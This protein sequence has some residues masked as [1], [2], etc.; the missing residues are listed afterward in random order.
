[1]RNLRALAWRTFGW[2]HK[3]D[4]D[5]SEEIESNVQLHIDDNLKQGMTPEQARRAA[6][7]KLGGVE[8]AKE[9]YRDRATL[10]LL[11]N[12]TGDIRFALRQLRTNPGFTATAILMLSLG[13]CASVAIFA[14]VDAALLK[15]LPYKD[16]NR[17]VGVYE[18][19]EPTCPLCNLSY[20]DYLDWKQSNTVFSSFAAYN[21]QSVIMTTPSGAQLALTTRVT[22]GFFRTLGVTPLLGRDFRSGEDLLSAPRTVMLS[23]STWQQRYAGSKDVLGK[24]I[25]LNGDANVVIGVLPRAFHFAPSEPTE[26][27]TTMHAASEC[28]LRR[29]CHNLYGIARLKDG[30]TFQTALADVTG[31]AKRLEKQ[32]PGSNRDQGAALAMISDVIVGNIRPILLVLLSGACLLL[33][34]AGVNVASLLLVRTESRKRE[35]AVRASVGASRGRIVAQ[36]MAEA[37]VLVA[38]GTT[39]GLLSAYA[40]M[41]LL[42]RLL[43][44]DMLLRMPYLKELVL[45]PRVLAFA[46]LVALLALLLFASIPALRV[47]LS[48]LREGL[49]EGSRGAG[50]TWRRLGSRL[51]VVEL[52]TAVVL[53]AG[54]GLLGQSLYRL[55]SVKIGLRPDHL[56]LMRVGVSPSSYPKD[57]QVMAVARRITT[58]I[59]AIPGVLSAGIVSNVP[60]GFSGNTTWFR[61]LGRPWQGEHNDTPFRTVSPDYFKTIGATLLRGRDFNQSEDKSKPRVVIIN[62]T[63]ARHFF[64]HEDPL[65]KQ[66]SHLGDH[67]EPITI[68]GIVENIKEG[69]LDEETRDTLYYPFNQDTDS[70]FALAVRT[71]QDESSVVASMASVIHRIDS[72][73][74]TLPGQTMAEHIAETQSAYTHRLLAA[75]VGGFAVLA[76]LLGAI[77]L[78]GVVAYSV[79]QR[80]REI[81]VRMALGAVRT[82]VYKL[83]LTEAG[84]LASA[85]IVIGIVCSI[86]A[87]NLMRSLLFEVSA[88]DPLTLASVA[89]VLGSAALLASFLPA[90][91]AASVNPVDALRAE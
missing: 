75:L 39:L 88:W 90:R 5:L 59:A 47:P 15:P 80:T 25:I 89:A 63:L 23:Y 43:S 50:N 35:L 56:V 65:G 69:P 3:A 54:A 51:V 11:E 78:Y 28:D 55:L 84:W 67:P 73:I 8:A 76:L 18:K 72:G 21:H 83:V 26:Y 62:Q 46:G 45:S 31:I 91:R 71:T 29:S 70:D 41:H 19:L 1:M 24:A 53:L 85:G 86:C 40:A 44:A 81:G 33:L 48:G 38:A 30:T 27:W 52:A 37:L 4:H 64:P 32:Y 20:L 74:I 22:D 13:M 87:A 77:G 9:A 16:P 57:E 42:S 49:A 36:F 58:Q 14:F 34:I 12:L 61:V 79:S 17:L 68:V 66:L 6:L 60:V 10:P 2:L 82:N 7:I